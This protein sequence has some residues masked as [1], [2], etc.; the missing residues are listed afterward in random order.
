MTELEEKRVAMAKFMG[1]K[2]ILVAPDVYRLEQYS[3]FVTEGD[4]PDSVW[5]L[6]SQTLRYDADWNAL[7]KVVERVENT[8]YGSIVIKGK[9]V[10][11]ISFDSKTY[12]YFSGTLI[13]NTFEACS[14][15]IKYFEQK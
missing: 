10:V 5:R 4:N 3:G 6:A 9:N 12:S 7:M 13:E 15:F 8:N 14:L 11:M 1:H 2:P